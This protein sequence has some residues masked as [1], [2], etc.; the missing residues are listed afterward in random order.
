MWSLSH[1]TT[2]EV[3]T[4]R[5]L[6]FSICQGLPWWL[7]GKESP[8]KWILSLSQED[9][10]EK[11][12]ASH[13]SILAWEI[14]W[15]EQPGGLQSMGLQ[16]QTRLRDQHTLLH[17]HV[18]VASCNFLSHGRGQKPQQFQVADCALMRRGTFTPCG[19]GAGVQM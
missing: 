7:N 12:V 2:K 16:S 17:S 5:I 13:S 8:C 4:L 14:P 3:P 10:L 19:P 15:T 18:L 1:W 6:V 11:E 9:P